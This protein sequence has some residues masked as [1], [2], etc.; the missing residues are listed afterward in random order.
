MKLRA[1]LAALIAFTT[2]ACA[3]SNA[4]PRPFPGAPIASAKPPATPRKPA[5]A[6]PP[7]D[8]PAPPAPETA[9]NTPPSTSDRLTGH[10]YDGRAVAE[11]ALALRGVP[12]RFGG[13]D[14]AGFDCS[15][16]VKY[17][18]ERYGIFV[19]R[20][21]EQQWQVGDKVKLRDIKAGDLL[22]FATSG[23]AVTHVAI[24]LDS[25]RFVHAPNSTGV[26]RVEALTSTY[27]GGHY[28]GARRITASTSSN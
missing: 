24:A 10:R 13:S 16:L 22:F 7:A 20:V 19:P 18:F 15:G 9:S 1:L 28:V 17:V 8:V 26:V 23:S 21:V 3:S 6:S 2:A 14:P 4:V 25:E 5:T 27:W 12:Y 11:F